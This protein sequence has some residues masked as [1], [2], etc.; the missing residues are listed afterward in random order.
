M[1]NPFAH[2][3]TRPALVFF[4]L[5]FLQMSSN[6]EHEENLLRLTNEFSNPN[7]SAYLDFDFT[8]T[9]RKLNR[10]A[11]RYPISKT[12]AQAI[13]ERLSLLSKMKDRRMLRG[14]ARKL[15][16]RPWKCHS[17]CHVCPPPPLVCPS[18]APLVASLTRPY[19]F[20]FFSA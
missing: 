12:E 18:V 19:C 20:S 14:E 15:S 6:F 13:S 10:D 4:H 7:S 16:T 17:P 3:R 9:A 5:F 8:K 2:R 11:T 1:S